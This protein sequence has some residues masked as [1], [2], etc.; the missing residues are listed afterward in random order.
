MDFRSALKDG[1]LCMALGGPCGSTAAVPSGPSPYQD[2]SVAGRR[3]FPPDI[4]QRSSSDHRSHFH[5]FRHKTR[6]IE[7][8]DLTGGQTDLISVRAIPRCRPPGNLALG[9]FPGQSICQWGSG[10]TGSGDPHSLIDVGPAG[11]GV[12]NGPAQASGRSSKGFY[13]RRMVMGFVLEHNHPV[14]V[15][16]VDIRFDP[17]AAGIDF[18]RLIQVL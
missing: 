15:F 2:D 18:F 12:P 4:F 8:P 16:P 6:M 14:L 9:Q 1:F 3:G 10:I 5:S 11:K 17:D 13:F 7:L